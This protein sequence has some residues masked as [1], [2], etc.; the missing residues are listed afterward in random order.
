MDD[1]ELVSMEVGHVKEEEE[2]EEDADDEVLCE[3]PVILCET[4]NHEVISARMREVVESAA[5]AAR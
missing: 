5:A 1:R 3:M 2:E 4:S